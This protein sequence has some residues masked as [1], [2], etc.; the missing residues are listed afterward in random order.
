VFTLPREDV[1]SVLIKPDNTPQQQQPVQTYTQPQQPAPSYAPQPQQAYAQ[2][3][4]R[5]PATGGGTFDFNRKRFGLDYGIG[6]ANYGENSETYFGQ[7]F[8]IHYTR[9]FIPY[10]G[11]NIFDIRA[12]LIK[13]GSV[14]APKDQLRFGSLEFLTGLR[15]VYPL[16]IKGGKAILSPFVATRLG[17]GVYLRDPD[18]S[19]PAGFAM[20][21]EAGVEF[22]SRSYVAFGY[23]FHKHSKD[24][25]GGGKLD[26]QVNSFT[27]RIGYQL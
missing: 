15:G 7:T 12:T 8:G 16:L 3:A 26:G 5:A 27:F 23:N 21:L 9:M 17:Y 11:W 1:F 24:L 19:V 2:P 20:D 6:G 4:N 10:I 18:R 14:S 22:L 25:D 13:D